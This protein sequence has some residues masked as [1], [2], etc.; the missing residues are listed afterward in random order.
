MRSNAQQL[1]KMH[2]IALRSSVYNAPPKW[3]LAVV[4]SSFFSRSRLILGS[5][6]LPAATGQEVATVAT[7]AAGCEQSGPDI[8]PKEQ[9]DMHLATQK[10]KTSHTPTH[11]AAASVGLVVGRDV[12]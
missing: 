3:R 9:C 11:L 6:K 5:L 8:T 12:K 4:V 7:A 10:S 1:T 2:S